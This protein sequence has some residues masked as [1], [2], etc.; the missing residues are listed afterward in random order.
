MFVRNY[1]NLHSIVLCCTQNLSNIR[2]DP[3]NPTTVYLTLRFHRT[4]QYIRR[5]HNEYSVGTQFC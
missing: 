3:S 2:S 1:F 5:Q 4:M